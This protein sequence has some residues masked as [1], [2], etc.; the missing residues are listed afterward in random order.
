LV[1]DLLNITNAVALSELNGPDA[2]GGLGDDSWRCSR[3]ALDGI[4]TSETL[5]TNERKE[6]EDQYAAGKRNEARGVGRGHC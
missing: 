4:L 5:I 6:D 2:V 3:K 1:E